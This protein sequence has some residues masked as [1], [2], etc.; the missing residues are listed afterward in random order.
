MNSVREKTS[1]SNEPICK[2]EMAEFLNAF[3][4]MMFS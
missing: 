3:R 1:E 2:E 4:E